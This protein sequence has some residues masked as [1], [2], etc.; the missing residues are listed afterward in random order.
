MFQ[1]IPN[2]SIGNNEP[3][4][5][6]TDSLFVLT[7]CNE[8]VVVQQDSGSSPNAALGNYFS[9]E[10]GYPGVTDSVTFWSPQDIQ[11]NGWLMPRCQIDDTTGF[12]TC[13]GGTVS[14]WGSTSSGYALLL[15][16][17]S[18]NINN[19]NFGSLEFLTVFDD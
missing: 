10:R 19:Y 3:L 17:N 13:A 11:N 9:F 8:L 12:I 2:G 7:N 18:P 4:S 6:S 1:D 5:A 16:P 14:Q 15:D